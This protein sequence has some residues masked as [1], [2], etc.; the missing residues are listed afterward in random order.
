MRGEA[1]LPM[2]GAAG[3]G[4]DWFEHTAGWWRVARGCPRQVLWVSYES[5][6]RDAGAEVR[7]VGEFLGPA[8]G[9]ARVREIVAAAGFAQMKARHEATDGRAG[10]HLRHVAEAGHFSRGEAGGW[11]DHF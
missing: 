10:A 7:R 5:L 3:D 2:G 6:L 11:R 9:E 1:P 8:A 4:A